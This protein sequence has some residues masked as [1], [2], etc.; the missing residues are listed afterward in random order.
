VSA[1]DGGEVVLIHGPAAA[2]GPA[3]SRAA[4]TAAALA[5]ESA[6]LSAEVRQQA[7]AVRESRRRLLAVADAERQA[8]ETRLQAGPVG[9]LHHVD[10]MLAGLR[11]QTAQDIRGQLGIALD[12]LA[13]LG[14]GLFP[15]ALNAHPLEKVLGELAAGMPIP[16]RVVTGGPL[17]A[18]TDE[19][20]A[21]AYFF[22]S[23]CLTNVARHARATTVTLQV[24]LDGDLLRMSMLDDGQGGATMTSARG[25]RGLADR[26]EV[27]GGQLTIDSPPGGPTRIRADVPVTQPG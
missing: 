4:A 22:C 8:L 24:L 2:A 7:R 14:Q 20:R 19:Q 10:Q 18:L 6:R 27:A 5:L 16:V 23:E 25:L 1:P 11:D 26:V 9:R 21:L 17:A 12:D 15:G 3:L 13:R